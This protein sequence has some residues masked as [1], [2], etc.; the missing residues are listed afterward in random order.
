MNRGLHEEI[1]EETQKKKKIPEENAQ[2]KKM[3]G[4]SG[5]LDSSFVS[6]C[7]QRRAP[8]RSATTSPQILLLEYKVTAR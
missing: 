4:T 5:N 7:S 1:S 6:V 3:E 2:K 8:A